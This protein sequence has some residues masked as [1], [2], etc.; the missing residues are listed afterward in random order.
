MHV[1]RERVQ[2][3]II[4]CPDKQD[5]FRPLRS[6]RTVWSPYLSH[7]CCYV[8]LQVQR[9]Y[10]FVG[11]CVT[12]DNNIIRNILQIILQLRLVLATWPPITRNINNMC[13]KYN[14]IQYVENNVYL[15]LKTTVISSS[16]E[17]YLQVIIKTFLFYFFNKSSFRDI[18]YNKKKI[19]ISY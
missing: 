6:N 17:P 18:L 3:R 15:R 13:N 8:S 1:L 11:I 12:H 10:Y 5:R 7:A 9:A 4:R 2:S 19:Y 16:L 14:N